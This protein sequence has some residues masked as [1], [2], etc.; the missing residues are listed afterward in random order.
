MFMEEDQGH[1]K[2]KKIGIFYLFIYFEVSNFKT[3]VEIS[4]KKLT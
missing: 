2:R 3:K 4:R 1:K